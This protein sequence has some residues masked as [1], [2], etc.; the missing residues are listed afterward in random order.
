MEPIILKL[1]T[2]D[3][4]DRIETITRSRLKMVGA[5]VGQTKDLIVMV[6]GK[7]V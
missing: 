1:S 4:K 3:L 6:A 2:K 7:R 5:G